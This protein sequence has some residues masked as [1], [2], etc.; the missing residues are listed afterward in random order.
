MAI[1]LIKKILSIFC[2][3]PLRHFLDSHKKI[4][5][6][7]RITAIFIVFLSSLAVFSYIWIVNNYYDDITFDVV[8]F[9]LRFP[10]VGVNNAFV[11]S[12]VTRALIPSIVVAIFFAIRPRTALLV[13]LILS[14]FLL[15]VQ[16]IIK[17]SMLVAWQQH[18]SLYQMIVTFIKGGYFKSFWWNEPFGAWFVLKAICWIVAICFIIFMLFWVGKKICKAMNLYAQIAL[19]IAVVALNFWII[20]SHF[21]LRKYF[22]PKE[23]GSFYDENY[24]ITFGD[25]GA[26]DSSVKDFGAKNADSAPTKEQKNARNLIVIFVESMEANFATAPLEQSQ[27]SPTFNVIPNLYALANQNV[28]FS[29]TKGFGGHLQVGRTSWTI[30]GMIGYM[31]GIPL[32]ATNSIIAKTFLP[33]AKCISDILATQNYNQVMIMGENDDFVAKGAFLSSHHIK[34]ND[35]KHYKDTGALPKDYSHQWGFEDSKL[36]QFAKDELLKLTKSVE[37]P[38]KNKNANSSIVSEKSGLRSH[39]RG[40]KTESLLTKRVAS[41]HDL[42][43]QDE[44]APFALYLLTNNTHS[45]DSF[46]EPHCKELQSK[47]Q[48]SLKCDDELL[49]E[50]VDWVKAQDFYKNTTILIVGDHLMNANLPTPRQ[51]RRIYNAFINPRFCGDSP[52]SSLQELQS[53][54]KQSASTS[55]LRGARSEASETKQSTKN[56]N[57]LPRFGYAESRNDEKWRGLPRQAKGLSRKTRQSRSFFSN[58]ELTKSRNLSHFDFAP[59]ILDSLGICTKSFGLGRNPFLGQ[60]LLETYGADFGRFINEDSRL[61]DSFWQRR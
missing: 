22:A 15:K 23:Y 35:I 50:F 25:F 37:N 38:T 40:N 43:P 6:T 33:S 14:A 48:S 47:R 58:D 61:Y 36:F 52:T 39:E 1:N 27:D 60:T 16:R 46:I 21:H 24:E 2:D 57:G 13:G 26:K 10:L 41:L 54:S 11:Y 4:R 34:S 44:F 9:H 59:L 55:S 45:P 18:I 30:A 8:L 19:F 32:N 20:D 49:G 51:S 29:T 3:S 42:S 5:I 56:T 53:D 28:N 31:C 7:L 12:Y 17:V